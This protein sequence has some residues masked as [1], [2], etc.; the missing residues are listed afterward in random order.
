MKNNTK[1]G[2]L[3]AI[4]GII[5]GL[6]SLYL[7]S[8]TYNSVIHT[9]FNAGDWEE[10]NT[11]RLVYAILGWLGT[12]AGAISVAVLW[13]FIKK[14]DWAWFWGTVSATILLLAGFFPMIPAM[15]SGLPVPTVAVFILAA[16]MWFGMLL[17]GG[18]N[19][20]IIWLTFTAGLAYVLTF[21][22]G[23]A[24]I[25][26]FQTTFQYPSA[27]VENSNTFWNGLY[28]ISQ[29]INWWGAAAWAI[30]IF[31][32][33][34]QKS[35]ALPVGLFAGAMSMIGGY[36]MGIHNVSEVNRFSMFLPAPI[37]STILVIILCLPK[38]QKLLMKQEDP[39][40]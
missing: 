22:D 6:L 34:K 32:A 15:D 23:V 27:F 25:S 7:I 35:W 40:I 10:S 8:D 3:L 4:I 2:M 11:V 14:Q 17:I 9:H 38:T 24:P 18:V 39:I 12:T 36:P 29:Q 13:G 1:L 30:F 16:I 19:K 21:I 31:A 20:K 5:A 37:L 28:I 33:I 26:K